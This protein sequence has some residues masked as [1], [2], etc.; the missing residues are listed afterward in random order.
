MTII[1]TEENSYTSF[2]NYKQV[3]YFK[4]S[5]LTA[6]IFC[7]RNHEKQVLL[8]GQNHLCLALFLD[9]CSYFRKERKFKGP[10]DNGNN[11]NLNLLAHAFKIP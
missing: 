2:I 10:I 8:I 6:G 1:N 9:S 3:E 4:S 7:T 5:L 11:I